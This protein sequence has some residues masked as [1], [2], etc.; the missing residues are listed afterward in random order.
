MS[1]NTH[2]DSWPQ[3]LSFAPMTSKVAQHIAD[4]WK[5]P[6]PY[7]FYNTTSD[8]DDYKEFVTP[9]LWPEQFWQVLHGDDV[10]G[11][12]TAERLNDEGAY[13]ISLGLRPDLTGGGHGL[14]FVRAGL[15]HVI[16]TCKPRCIRL[17]VAAFNKRAI[18]VYKEAGFTIIRTYAQPTNGDIYDFV[19]MELH[20]H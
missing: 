8:P 20:H 1:A 16:H 3:G 19:E 10:V 5:Y 6:A 17:S 7:D 12:F 4:T 13:E 14:A 9:A 15:D 2:L 11:F 18:T